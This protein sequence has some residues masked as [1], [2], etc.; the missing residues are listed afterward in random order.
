M[1]ASAF[2]SNEIKFQT[3]PKAPKFPFP[4]FPQITDNLKFLS[5]F[6]IHEPI[7][8]GSKRDR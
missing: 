8:I 4:T 3:Q 6:F 7:A 1:F 5:T 2:L